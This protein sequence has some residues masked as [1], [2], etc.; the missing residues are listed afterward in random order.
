MSSEASSLLGPFP[1]P[2][3][4]A[5]RLG[6]K[7]HFSVIA[8]YV[9]R[10]FLFGFFVCF[11]FFFAVF[12]V[13]QILLMAEDILSRKA[14]LK[15]VLLL[16]V[17]AMP[18]VVAMSFPFASLVGALMAAGRL[19]SD[20]EMLAIMAAGIP[21][22]RAFV[23][24]LVLGLAFS[25]VS[26]VMN[27]YF[28]PRGS[29]EFNKLYRRLAA[30]IPALELKPWSSRRYK[31]ITVVTGD[32]AGSKIKD[33]LIFDRSEGDTQRVI[34]AGEA[35]LSV[36]D[37][38]GD[39]VLKLTDV[40]QH[41]IKTGESD[42]FE[43]ARASNME[44]RIS[45]REQEDDSTVLGPRDMPSVDLAKVISDKSAALDLRLEKRDEDVSLSR[46]SLM[47]AYEAE[48]A[49]DSPWANSA[50]RLEPALSALRSAEA[51]NPSDRT[52]QVYVLEY[53]KKFSIPF[54]ALFF[55]V[56][57]FPLGLLA[58]KSG[59]TMGFGMGILIA[60]IYWAFLIGG[61]T[62]GSRLSWSPFWSSWAPNAIVLVTGLALWAARLRTR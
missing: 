20:N 1:G 59:R 2:G 28:L 42:R 52:L 58:K 38:R 45:M 39:V 43:W 15:D 29:I 4:A 12:F 36:D 9:S 57:A 17:F 40:W 16:L 14:Q 21:P 22:R 54:G 50:A 25:L 19:S 18:S 27:D 13:N 62:F 37:E 6:G 34:S 41:T 46:A 24:F 3:I 10:E 51:S 47:A 30:S 60:V 23:P 26:F 8:G 5:R 56:L 49:G 61:Q 44:Y 53:W 35:S 48:L 55:V 7:A 31:D 33:L 32:M 11:L